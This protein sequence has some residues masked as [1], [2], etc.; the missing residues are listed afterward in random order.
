MKSRCKSKH[1]PCSNKRKRR[2]RGCRRTQGSCEP[3]WQHFGCARAR[4]FTVPRLLRAHLC[5]SEHAQEVERLESGLFRTQ[6]CWQLPPP[7]ATP[8]FA[9]HACSLQEE[10][11]VAEA[12]IRE[13]EPLADVC[14]TIAGE[15]G[16]LTESL[17]ATHQRRKMLDI[18][19]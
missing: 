16:C 10:L 18:E 9:S 19:K 5:Q 6:V 14:G 13:L 2:L 3:S 12:R 8:V 17:P 1:G 7:A 11:S 15:T 4:V